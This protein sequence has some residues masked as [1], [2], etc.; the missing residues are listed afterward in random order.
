[1][2]AEKLSAWAQQRGWDWRFTNLDANPVNLKSGRTAKTVTG[3][4]LQPPFANGVL[5]LS[6]LRK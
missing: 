2:L 5:I 3:S 1:L 4:A 6:S